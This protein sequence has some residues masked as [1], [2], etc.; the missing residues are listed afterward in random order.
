MLFLFF[1]ERNDV[2]RTR[3]F[4]EIT[5]PGYRP[6]TFKRFFRMSRHSFEVLYQH[7]AS[8]RE[9]HPR[10]YPG[11]RQEL[12]LEKALLMILR[13]LASQETIFEISDRFDITEF[14]F[15][16]YRSLIVNA[17]N[18]TLL[19]KFIA[20][21]DANQCD[22]ISTHFNNMG[23]NPFPNV[24][25]AV[26]GTHIRIDPPNVNPNAYFNRKKFHSIIL[27]GVCKHDLQFTNVY[28]GWPGRVHDAR[29]LRN[30]DLWE[31]GDVK[32]QQGHFHVL[33]DGA[34]LLKR[35][36]MTPYRDTG[37]LTRS[38]IRYNQCLS[39][40]RQVIER[41][42]GLLKGRFR[43]LK[44]ICMKK[45]EEICNLIVAS[46]VLH[47]ICILN[48]EDFEEFMD[49]DNELGNAI[50]PVAGNFPDNNAEGIL[51]RINLTNQ[52]GN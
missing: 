26:D 32:C 38:Q 3:N 28:T 11:G 35:W 44:H 1:S 17:I 18:R 46:C 50:M 10:N 27:Q 39:S 4:Y 51:K 33:G 16:K 30:S 31:N 15:L 7:L 42:F 48:G 22:E 49:N 52:L 6:D 41:A 37:H 40:K 8:C 9:L 23:A 24:I 47:N 43:R 12:P 19:R 21:P 13:Y 5:V 45:F 25:G 14:T 34:Y 36:L 20:W 2:E 29:V